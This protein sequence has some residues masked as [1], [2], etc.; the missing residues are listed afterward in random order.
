MLSIAR[1][2]V[3]L[4]LLVAAP[5]AFAQDANNPGADI[6]TQGLVAPDLGAELQ[7]PTSTLATPDAARPVMQAPLPL[8]PGHTHKL[9]L[10]A[11]LVAE[12]APVTNGLIWR[13][14][15]ARPAANGELP[16][17]TETAPGGTTTVQLP[18]GDYLVHAAFGRAGATKRVAIADD[19]QVESLVLDA[20]GLKL[21]FGGRR[22]SADPSRPAL[23]RGAAGG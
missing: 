3:T 15:G 9:V 21:E 20:G 19:D 10:E 22:R 7:A 18:P 2:L 17:I 1:V 8:V 6:F 13:V 11:R 16:L 14:F 4:G 23:L 12:G 5:A